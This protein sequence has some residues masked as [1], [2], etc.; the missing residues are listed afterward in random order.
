MN[1]D[2]FLHCDLAFLDTVMIGIGTRRNK[3]TVTLT[4]DEALKL[5]Y[6]LMSL[7]KGGETQ[8]FEKLERRNSLSDDG[9]AP[10]S[11]R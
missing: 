5:A 11:I 10:L 2:L 9:R 3:R 4:A 1:N 6:R 8:G 7:G